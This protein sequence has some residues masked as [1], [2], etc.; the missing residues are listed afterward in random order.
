MKDYVRKEIGKLNVEKLSTYGPIPPSILKQCI[1]A[2]LPYLTYSISYSLRE[3]TFLEELKHSEL[4]PVYKKLDPLKKENYRPVSFL[5]DVSK[6]FEG[7]I[8][9]K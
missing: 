4:I 6:V 7:I 5:P 9:Q 3:S 8:Y 2:Y 1:D